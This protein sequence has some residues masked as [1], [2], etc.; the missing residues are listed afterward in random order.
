MERLDLSALENAFTSLALTIAKLADKRWFTQQDAI[1]Q[2]TLIAGAIQKFEFVYELSI[3]M[4][5][6]QLKLLAA[7]PEEI[8]SSDF[9]DILRLSARSGLIDTVEDWLLYRK[10]RNVTSHTYDQDKAQQIYQQISDFL[11]S[12]QFLLNQLKQ[13]NV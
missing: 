8:D 3:K 4:M 5:K 11:Q 12:A 1:V 6:R 9:R 10:M 7:V 2:D 13:H